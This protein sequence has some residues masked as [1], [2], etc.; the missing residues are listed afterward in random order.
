MNEEFF[1]QAEEALKR[2]WEIHRQA[3]GPI[4]EPAFIENQQVRIP[5]IAALNKISRRDTK[6][7]LKILKTLEEHCIYDEDKAAWS[8]FVGLAYEMAGER[9]KMIKWYKRAGEYGHRFYLP[10]AKIAKHAHMSAHFDEALENYALAVDCVLR[11]PEDER[12]LAVVGSS[13]ANM[14]SCL[15]MMHRYD[16]A[17]KAWIKAQKYPLQPGADAT[18][19]ILYAAMDNEEKVEYYIEELKVEFPVWVSNTVVM[20]GQILSGAHPH[21]CH[22]PTEPEIIENFWAWFSE[23]ENE[24]LFGLMTGSASV[25][26]SFTEQLKPL[27]PYVERE[28]KFTVHGEGKRAQVIFYDYYAIALHF[29]YKEL[30]A[31]CPQ[32][33]R[34][35]WSFDIVH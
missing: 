28:P 3:F 30:I 13:Y 33:L 11:L 32:D 27:F 1:E 22:I 6:E 21:F 2:S 5:L 20:T 34:E 15:T 23:N 17:E 35:R 19:A 8:F 24:L 18:A 10:Y 4:L 25:I 26:S 14:V 31:A 9:E 7:G 29:G 16:E 12:E